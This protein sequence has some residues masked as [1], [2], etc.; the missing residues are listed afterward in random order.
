MWPNLTKL[1][2]TQH[3][4]NPT[5]FWVGVGVMHPSLWL[6][7]TWSFFPKSFLTQILLTVHNLTPIFFCQAQ[8]TSNLSSNWAGW[9]GFIFINLTIFTAEVSHWA[10]PE[11]I[12]AIWDWLFRQTFFF[13]NET[14]ETNETN[15][16]TKPYIEAACCLKNMVAPLPTLDICRK[17]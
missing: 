4:F 13:T 8:P 2:T 17:F 10:T 3:K 11:V 12:Q 6:N 7:P 14:N 16:H 9:V 5:I 1:T 15:K